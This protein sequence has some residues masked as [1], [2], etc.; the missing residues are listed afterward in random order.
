[1]SWLLDHLMGLVDGQPTGNAIFVAGEAGMGKTSLLQ[2]FADRATEE[3]P[4][5]LPTWKHRQYQAIIDEAGR[6]MNQGRRLELYHQADKILI[7]EAVVL[8]LIH[9]RW[10]F[11]VKPRISNWRFGADDSLHLRNVIIEPS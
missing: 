3:I 10:H 5:L 7:E 6:E 11:L 9:Q 1:V 8:P 4:G 2:A